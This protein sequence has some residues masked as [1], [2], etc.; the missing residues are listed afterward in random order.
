MSAQPSP[1]ASP[2]HEPRV[3]G[4]YQL[5]HLLGLGGMGEVWL[6]RH[7]ETGGLAAVKLLR[8]LTTKDRP[9]A[10]ALFHDERRAV[11]RLAHP[12]VVSWHE[13]GPEHIAMRYVRGTDLGRA[14]K[15]PMPPRQALRIATQIASALAHA[16]ARGIAHR[17]VKPANILLDARGNAHLTDFGVA[18]FAD[19]GA[20]AAGRT[21]AGT[22]SYMAPEQVTGTAA[23][24]A[25]DQYSLART[26]IAM[27]LGRKPPIDC[28]AALAE[29]PA[30]L[31]EPLVWA[32]GRAT[33]A[34]PAARFPSMSELGAALELA[35]SGDLAGD[36]LLEVLRDAA[37]FRWAKG[38][39]GSARL[40]PQLRRTDYLLSGLEASG[41][42]RPQACAAFRARTGY[43]DFGWSVYGREDTL[44]RLDAPLAFARARQAVLLAHGFTNVRDSWQ[45]VAAPLCRDHG[46]VVVVAPDLYG[47]G[48]S[49]VAEPVDPARATPRAA[50]AS[51]VAFQELIGTAP[52][53]TLLVGHSMGATALLT[54]RDDELPAGMNRVAITP[55]F[56]SHHAA[57][58]AKLQLWAFILR[59]FGRSS[60]MLH[61]IA[62]KFVESEEMRDYTQAEKALAFKTMV[63]AS[64]TV[65]AAF[66]DGFCDAAPADPAQLARCTIVV[67]RGDPIASEKVLV[68][69]LRD[70]GIG[71]DRVRRL[72]GGAHA[73]QYE[74]AE[75]P[76]WTARNVGEIVDYLSERLGR[77]QGAIVEVPSSGPREAAH[78]R[79]DVTQ[80]MESGPRARRAG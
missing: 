35:L 77:M 66:A 69:A 20:S 7:V 25:C 26:L 42:L 71:S 48:T 52:I 16:H 57:L 5:E 17:D 72:V 80:V 59:T 60:R 15:K 51:L 18:L 1:V 58:R 70:L 43:A 41:L 28:A 11:A 10:E 6:G 32:I 78:G 37:P 64:P 19:A 68:R 22:P 44:G 27:L 12:H 36:E 24:P 55:V 21:C 8:P 53:P 62:G 45:A 67:V 34:D 3:V 33:A 13:I 38:A 75:H 54:C 31:P 46:D 63:E 50:M 29:L 14:L 40:A 73:P 30:G 2:S 47:F 76:E 23:G 49:K 56:P 61:N 4:S 74:L 39:T 79:D 65:Q 9:L